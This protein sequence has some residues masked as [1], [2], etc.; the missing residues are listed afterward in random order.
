VLNEKGEEILKDDSKKVDL[1]LLKDMSKALT[2]VAQIGEFGCKKYS[3]SSWLKVESPRYEAALL[4]HV[5][6]EEDL[7]P[8]SQ[9]LH[10]AHAAW[11]ALAILELKLRKQKMSPEITMDEVERM[12]T[13]SAITIV[14]LEERIDLLERVVAELITNIPRKED[15]HMAKKTVKKAVAVKAAKKSGKKAC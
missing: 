2:A 9:L 1:T 12:F 3:R 4:R 13:A 7:D 15:N 5:F 14:S 10:A 8:D 11:N 6:T